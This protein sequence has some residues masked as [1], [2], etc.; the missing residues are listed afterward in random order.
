MTFCLEHRLP[1]NHN[2][3]SLPKERSWK[4]FR[5]DRTTTLIK[6]RIF[7]PRVPKTPAVKIPFKLAERGS[8]EKSKKTPESKKR[9]DIDREKLLIDSYREAIKS[10]KFIQNTDTG[11]I[12]N[13]KSVSPKLGKPR[14]FGKG[15]IVGIS[16][17]LL[18]LFVGLYYYE[19][20]FKILFDE[21]LKQ[22][23]DLVTRGV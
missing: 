16:L 11:F 6:P 2:C 3:I 21:V 12:R 10:G 4:A 18:T 7:R 1:E 9:H 20:S 15:I 22:F 23:K 5:E 14:K 8:R 17:I 19:P 13:E